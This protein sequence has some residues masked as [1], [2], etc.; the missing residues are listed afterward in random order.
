MSYPEDI[1]NMPVRLSRGDVE[2][3]P[4]ISSVEV[5]VSWDCKHAHTTV[6]HNVE[7]KIKE[8]EEIIQRQNSETFDIYTL[9]KST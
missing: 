4:G 2:A 6:K 9:L 5:V 1:V 7:N 3:M 8:E